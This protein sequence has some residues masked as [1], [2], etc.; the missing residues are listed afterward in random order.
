MT[1]REKLQWLGRYR[2][3]KSRERLLLEEY[4]DLAQHARELTGGEGE[5]PLWLADGLAEARRELEM[6]GARC[7]LLR[8]QLMGAISRL[9]DER[10]REVLRRRFLLGQTAAQAADEMGVVPRR[11]EQLQTEGVRALDTRPRRRRTMGTVG[12]WRPAED[13]QTENKNG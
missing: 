2:R 11:V 1:N 9:D 8:R 12:R 3:E 13:K 7:L 6:Q 4:N 10:Q 5:T